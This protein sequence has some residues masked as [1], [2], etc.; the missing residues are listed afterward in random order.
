MKGVAHC[1][2]LA[3]D[4]RPHNACPA[5]YRLGASHQQICPFWGFYL[6][7]EF[8]VWNITTCGFQKYKKDFSTISPIIWSRILSGIA[9]IV[10][11]QAASC[12]VWEN[13]VDRTGT[14]YTISSG[15]LVL[16]ELSASC[17][18]DG[19]PQSGVWTRLVGADSEAGN[20]PRTAASSRGAP[21]SKALHHHLVTSLPSDQLVLQNFSVRFS[22]LFSSAFV[23]CQRSTFTCCTSAEMKFSFVWKWI[24][25][26]IGT[27]KQYKKG[28]S[29]H[30]ISRPPYASAWLH[31]LHWLLW[32][33]ISR[34]CPVF[35]ILEDGTRKGEN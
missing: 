13:I 26:G 1:A 7:S 11:S 5:A 14:R 4:R 9:L 8:L 32:W 31:S 21:F 3:I 10:I 17:R 19:G 23:S 30:L 29:F 22:T 15:L 25:I 12:L 27:T 6:R 33:S 28:V 16:L 2:R 18:P 20:S 24:N 35:W 34:R